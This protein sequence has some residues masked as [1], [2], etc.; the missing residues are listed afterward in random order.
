M[1]KSATDVMHDIIFSAVVDAVAALK[2]GSGG[3]PNAL[4]RDIAAIHANATFADLPKELQASV[5]ASVRAGFNRLLKE[6]YAVSPSQP[7]ARSNMPAPAQIVPRNS[8]SR[9]APARSAPAR[10]PDRPRPPRPK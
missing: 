1:P 2:A 10:K 8:T 6:G 4:L 9:P 3:V 7:V 5:T